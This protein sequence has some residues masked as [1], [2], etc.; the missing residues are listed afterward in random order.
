[1]TVSAG[2]AKWGEHATRLSDRLSW[3]VERV[4]ALL[5]ILLVL[6]VWL[7]VLARYVL[8]IS[9]TF[10]EEAARY[11]MIWTA[12]LAVSCGIARRE[13]IGLMLLFEGMPAAPRRVLLMVLDVLAFAFF[14]VLLFY[15]LGLVE[16]GFNRF[17]MIHG[18]NKAL[19]F[20]AVPVSAA[21]A[22]LQLVLVAV[23]DQAGLHGSS[24]DV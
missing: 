7:G 21:L 15:G 6:D 18:I 17:T 13:H 12:L 5:L 11:L 24:T 2:L 8:P 23:R 14:A 19:P 9:F 1:M 22:C 20:A 4:C 16:K 10:T 3:L